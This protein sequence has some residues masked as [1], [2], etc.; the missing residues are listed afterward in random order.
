MKKS[1]N[2][3]LNYW[4]KKKIK[5]WIIEF[6]DVST[7]EVRQQMTTY[8]ENVGYL[9]KYEKIKKIIFELLEN[10]KIKKL[11]FELLEKERIKKW[12]I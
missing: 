6:L 9:L 4:K 8:W 1:K 10:E 7:S 5:K 11:N 12:I 2:E 3:I